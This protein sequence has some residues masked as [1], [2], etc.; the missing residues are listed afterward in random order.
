M[1][2]ILGKTLG[3]ALS[4]AAALSVATVPASAVVQ[5]FGSN[6]ANFSFT[7]PTA[8]V[9]LNNG[10]TSIPFNI[11]GAA[12]VRVAIT[13][14]A[15]CAVGAPAGNTG[16]WVDIDILV[17]G[18]AVSPTNQVND[19]FCSANGSAAVDGWAT[20]SITVARLLAPGPHRL[21]VQGRLNNGATTGWLS[22][23][24]T[25]IQR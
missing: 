13:F 24:A 7:T 23:T 15:E 19:A 10:A 22:D 4:T 12:N 16:A 11:P 21:T 2:N 25:V 8:L 20:N 14:S 5:A 6:A 18:V 3:L 9:P 1:R 17:D